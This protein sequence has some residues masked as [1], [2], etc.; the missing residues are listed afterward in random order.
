MDLHACRSGQEA[1][2]QGLSV[3]DVLNHLQGEL[4]RIRE[5]KSGGDRSADTLDN[6]N[7]QLLAQLVREIIRIRRRR[8]LHFDRA[9]FGEPAWDMLLEVYAAD[10]A[11]QRISTSNLCYASAVPHTTALRWLTK[12]I[13]EGWLQR[14]RDPLDDRRTWVSL[15]L[16]AHE[17]MR[18]FLKN[19]GLR[20]L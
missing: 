19:V 3:D 8:E 11:Q 15:T 4:D 6:D 18:A 20:P 2:D 13:D 10:Y 1:D 16:K 5:R 14:A 17:A 7:E 12:L 9:L